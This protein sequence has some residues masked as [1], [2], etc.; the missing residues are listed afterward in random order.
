PA[1]A[2]DGTPE[3]QP[4]D[5]AARADA[6]E[7][8][9]DIATLCNLSFRASD[10]VR[11]ARVLRVFTACHPGVSPVGLVAGNP[12]LTPNFGLPAAAGPRRERPGAPTAGPQPAQSGGS[13]G[14]LTLPSTTIRFNLGPAAFTVDLPASLAVR[15]PVAFRGGSVVISLN[16]STDEFSFSVTINAVRHVR[17]IAAAAAT[18]SGRGS[19][20][21]TL[22]TTR[23]TC[24]AV[25]AESGRRQLQAAGGRLRDA[26]LAV[27]NPPPLP[28]D[29]GE[30]RETFDPHI[31]LGEVAAAVANVHSTIERVR[32]RCREVPVAS[33][34]FGVEGPLTTPE[35]G[36]QPGPTF[37]GGSLRLHF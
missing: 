22:E 4:S 29:A 20:G 30:L 2:R 5:A 18:T 32:S 12:C 9:C 25:D 23:T 35:P 24:R 36:T 15:L 7:A 37:I 10:V 26:I 11:P 19:A 8:T 31:R 17:I 28:A 1:L 13:P 33:L 3:G 14:G 6:A 16:A 21:L 34:R 27:Q